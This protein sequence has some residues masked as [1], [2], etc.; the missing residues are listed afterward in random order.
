MALPAPLSPV[1]HLF[2]R[3]VNSLKKKLPVR[4]IL[5]NVSPCTPQSGVYNQIKLLEEAEPLQRARVRQNP[6]PG[7]AG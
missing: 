5:K 3:G 6:T 7:P 2:L 4:K 1:P